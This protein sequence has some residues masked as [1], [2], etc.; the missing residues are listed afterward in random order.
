MLD[1]RLLT[2]N[3]TADALAGEAKALARGLE[4]GGERFGAGRNGVGDGQG[5]L[6]AWRRASID[7]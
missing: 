3:H 2:E 1:H 4:L 6:L 7:G 5:L